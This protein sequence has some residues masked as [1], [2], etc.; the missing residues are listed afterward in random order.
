MKT[1]PPAKP[2]QKA[3]PVVQHPLRKNLFQRLLEKRGAT[4]VISLLINGL[5][6]LIASLLVV[7]VV[8]GRKKMVFTA[9]PPSEA[10]KEVEHQVQMAKKTKSMGA[11]NVT[12]LITSSAANVSIALPPVDMSSASPDVMSSVMNGIGGAGLGMGAGLGGAGGGGG[13]PGGAFTSFGFQNA[14]AGTLTGTLFDLKQNSAGQPLP[15]DDA[16]FG[17]TSEK[18]SR[19]GFSDS[20]LADYYKAPTKLYAAQWYV[21]FMQGTEAA[22]A[23]QLKNADNFWII[24]YQGVVIPKVSGT[25]RFWGVAD[26]LLMVQFDGNLVLNY[27][28][29]TPGNRTVPTEFRLY[30]GLTRDQWVPGRGPIMHGLMHGL[31]GGETFEVHAGHR[32]PID[33]VFGNAEG[34]T[35]CYLLIEK[36]GET[37]QQDSHGN[38]IL[39]IFKL[40]PVPFTKPDSE[41]TVFAPD[42][43]FSVWSSEKPL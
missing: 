21:P 10:P 35:L 30:D 31:G 42:T 33:I 19:E 29:F 37:Y 39:P 11:P 20:A 8:Q 38:P 5:V 9:P 17:V 14:S 15:A 27:G 41:G 4:F 32:Y 40:A 3:A 23:F 13:M 12:K 22:K 6:I 1:E 28:C 7:H 43:K 18:Y 26:D 36:V 34:S 24:H 2:P 25:Y 16:S